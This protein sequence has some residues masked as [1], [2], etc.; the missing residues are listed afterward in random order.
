MLKRKITTFLVIAVCV[1][2]VS[3]QGRTSTS[4]L[5]PTEELVTHLTSDLEEPG[6]TSIC[7]TPEEILPFAFTPEGTK[8][9]VRASSGVQ[10]FDLKTGEQKTFI[11]SPQ[12]VVTAALSLD[13]RTLAWS[14]QDNTIQLIRLSDQEVLATLIEHPDPVFDLRFS[15]TG[16]R[17]FSASHDGL[18]R[19]WDLSGKR[20]ASIETGGEVLGIGLSW[21]GSKLATIPFDGP[22]QLWDLTENRK[23]AEF[24]GSGGYDTSDAHFSPDGQYLAADLATGLFLWRV[25]DAELLWNDIKNSMAIAFSPDGQYLAYSDVDDGNVVVLASPDGT[26]VV[27]TL[28]RMQGPVWEMFFS[29]D[30]SLLAATD[31]IEIHIWRVEDGTLLYIGRTICP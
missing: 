23:I 19:I 9:M 10:I 26:R 17:L 11:H 7:F 20:L 14:L 13:G 24:M 3:C 12:S 5:S 30:G 1:L 28:E 2:M 25:S 18:V 15:P 16:D 21:D 22:V 8:L 27:R 29:P 31:G 6:S 4:N